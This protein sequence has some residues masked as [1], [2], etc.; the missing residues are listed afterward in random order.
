M[1]RLAGRDDDIVYYSFWSF[2]AHPRVSRALEHFRADVCARR[3]LI[4]LSLDPVSAQ[5]AV[6][7]GPER[8]FAYSY[9]FPL[10]AI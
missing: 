9:P 3:L 2:L 4:Q 5:E 10:P 6:C 7:Q 8:Q 1:L